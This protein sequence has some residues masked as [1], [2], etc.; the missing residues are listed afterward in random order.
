MVV[1]MVPYDLLLL[2]WQTSTSFHIQLPNLQSTYT[3]IWKNRVNK[4]AKEKSQN[5]INFKYAKNS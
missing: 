1:H 4:I 3:L 5:Q 2:Q